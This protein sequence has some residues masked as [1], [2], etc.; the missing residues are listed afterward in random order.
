M[1]KTAFLFALIVT[2]PALAADVMRCG[3][4]DFGNA[5][6]LDKDGVLIP[7]PKNSAVG[8]LG[9]ASGKSAP[10]NAGGESGSTAGRDDIGKRMRC[11]IDQFGNTVCR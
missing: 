7:A 1:H 10:A 6:C 9:E 4:D 8:K 5:V 11:A 3:T 2:L